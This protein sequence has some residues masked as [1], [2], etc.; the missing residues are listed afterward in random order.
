MRSDEWRYR[1]EVIWDGI[2]E[3]VVVVVTRMRVSVERQQKENSVERDGGGKQKMREGGR[4]GKEER[5]A[6]G[7]DLRDPFA[8]RSDGLREEERAFC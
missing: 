1:G 5:R 7:R 2:E 3:I 8:Q 4:G 6:P